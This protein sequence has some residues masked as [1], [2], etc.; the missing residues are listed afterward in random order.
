MKNALIKNVVAIEKIEEDVK[1]ELKVLLSNEKLLDLLLTKGKDAYKKEL[2]LQLS[3]LVKKYIE[4][5]ENIAKKFVNE[6]KK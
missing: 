5:S 4:K 3:L 2:I 1:E 6:V